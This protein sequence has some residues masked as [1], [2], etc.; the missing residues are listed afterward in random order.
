LGSDFLRY[1]DDMEQE[2]KV[3]THFVPGVAATLLGVTGAN[4]RRWTKEGKITA[5]NTPTGR[6]Y[7]L[8]TVL[9]LLAERAASPS[10]MGRPTTAASTAKVIQGLRQALP[11]CGGR[12]RKARVPGQPRTARR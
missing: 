5:I 10:R 7:A 8:A 1:H 11:A 9:A 12:R 3:L 2:L 6:R 4:L